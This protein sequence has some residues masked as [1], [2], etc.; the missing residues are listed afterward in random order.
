MWSLEV[1]IFDEFPVDWESSVFKIVGSEP[2]FNLSLRR[3]LPDSAE[4]MLDAMLLTDEGSFGT[5][6]TIMITFSHRDF[7]PS[8]ASRKNLRH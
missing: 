5:S 8:S 3:R 4:N 6:L 2:A 7:R 1:V